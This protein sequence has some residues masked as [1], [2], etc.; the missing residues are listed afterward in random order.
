M[1]TYGIDEYNGV[2]FRDLHIENA[3]I[4]P[5]GDI[6]YIDPLIQFLSDSKFYKKVSICLTGT[7]AG[8]VLYGR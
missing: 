6:F 7:A 2:V 4:S 5:N 3:V 1:K 8:I